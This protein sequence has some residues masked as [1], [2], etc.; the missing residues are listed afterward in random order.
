[1]EGFLIGVLIVVLLVRWVQLRDR[2][3]RMQEQMDALQRQLQWARKMG[4]LGGAATHA[5]APASPTVTTPPPVVIPPMV[6]PPMAPV[7]PMPVA[8]PVEPLVVPP[9]AVVPE[10]AAVVPPAPVEPQA[11]PAPSLPP[12]LPVPEPA[13]ARADAEA[14]RPRPVRTSADWEALVGGN[15][16]NKL[17]VFILV[18]GIALALGYSFTMMGPGGRVAVSVAVSLALL[19]SGVVFERRERYRTFARGLL[20]GGWAALY[21]T[22]YAA[23]AIDADKVIDSPAAGAL[24]LLAVAAGMVLH[25]LR[26]HSETVTGVAYFLAFVTL[27]ITHVTALAVVAL[28]PLAASILYLAHRFAWHKMA[29]LGLVATYA[30]CGLQHDS[31]APLWQ[32]QAIFTV[33][34]LLFEGFDILHPSP[35][36]LPLNA[37]GFLGLSLGK[38]HLAA[39]G[40][41]WQIVTAAGV[42]YLASTVIRAR[43]SEWRWSVTLTGGLAVAA[44]FMELDRQWIAF[45]LLMEAELY[46]LAGLAVRLALSALA[47]RAGVRPRAGADDRGG[48]A[49]AAVSRLDADSGAGCRAV[50]YQPCAAAGGCGIRVRRRGHDGAGGGLRGTE[51][52]RAGVVPA[53]RGAVRSGLVAA[54]RGFPL[55]GVRFVGDGADRHGMERA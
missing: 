5:P 3:N 14:P 42:A 6:I 15:W 2:L 8:A 13:F 53:G 1:M 40:R 21:F 34:W 24:L 55:P 50:L 38:W 39:P 44:I 54:A 9:P 20:G 4:E 10:P 23:Q 46:Y 16:L 37:I 36:L 17:G 30:V 28:V 7:P 12:V 25:S 33:Y 19:I 43:R 49:G 29:I 11:P 41:E 22:V 26:Y 27:G 35:F 51:R 32:A 31:G 18:V 45:A 48:P 52:P 47:G